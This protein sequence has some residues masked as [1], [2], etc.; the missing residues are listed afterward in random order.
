MTDADFTLMF[1][2]LKKMQADIGQL[3]DDVRTIKSEIVLINQH[4]HLIHAEMFHIQT[5]HAALEQRVSRIEARLE[6]RDQ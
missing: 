3:K 2:M 6:L 1:D 4:I 5:G